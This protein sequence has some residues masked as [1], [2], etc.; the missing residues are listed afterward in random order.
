MIRCELC[1]DTKADVRHCT[2][3]CARLNMQGKWI[4][5][6]TGSDLYMPKDHEHKVF[7]G[8]TV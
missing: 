7:G 3:C 5:P 1:G 4:W 6:W 2:Q 8:A